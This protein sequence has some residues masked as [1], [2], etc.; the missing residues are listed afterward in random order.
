MI[1]NGVERNK[2]PNSKTESLKLREALFQSGDNEILIGLIGRF[3]RLKG[4]KLLIE[5]FKKV[6][7]KFQNTKLCF[8]GSPPEGQEHFLDDIVKYIENNEMTPLVTILPFQEDIYT[9]IDTLDIVVVPSTEPESFGI[10]AVESMLSQ[11]AVIAS[12]LG[13]L[14]DVISHNETGILFEPNN[15]ESLTDAILK[16]LEDKEFK[17]LIELKACQKAQEQFSSTSMTKNFIS[18]Y[19][20]IS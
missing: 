13:G 6:H 1:F 2:R 9:I 4:H 7:T 11:K 3:N 15:I 20:A 14:A 5:A 17:E 19:N 18:L 8:I 10:V 16:L 12:N